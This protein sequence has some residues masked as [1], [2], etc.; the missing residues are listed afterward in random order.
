MRHLDAV[1]GRTGAALEPVQVVYI[2]FHAFPPIF[3]LF[4]SVPPWPPPQ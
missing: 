3:P 4:S 1:A 2:P